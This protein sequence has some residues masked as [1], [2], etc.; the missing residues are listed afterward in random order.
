MPCANSDADDL[1][2]VGPLWAD[3][4]GPFV[5]LWASRTVFVIAAQFALSHSTVI[6]IYFVTNLVKFTSCYD[7]MNIQ[8]LHPVEKRDEGS[9]PHSARS[10]GW[11]VKASGGP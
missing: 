6:G 2:F 10:I 8:P 4:Y 3:R 5:N 11:F 1:V 9:T 7:F